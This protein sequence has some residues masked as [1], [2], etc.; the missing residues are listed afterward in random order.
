MMRPRKKTE[1]ELLRIEVYDGLREDILKGGDKERVARERLQ[2]EFFMKV[3]T[4]EE[5]KQFIQE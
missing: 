3:Y 5:V 2:K 1:S 4:D